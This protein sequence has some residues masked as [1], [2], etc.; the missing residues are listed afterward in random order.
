VPEEPSRSDAHRRSWVSSRIVF[1]YRVF[2]GHVMTLSKLSPMQSGIL[3][4]HRP[5]GFVLP[6]NNDHGLRPSDRFRANCDIP[7]VPL[8]HVESPL[9]CAVAWVAAKRDLK[10]VKTPV[11]DWPS[12]Q[13]VSASINWS[14]SGKLSV[15]RIS[16]SS[17]F[18]CGP[19]PPN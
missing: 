5:K 11:K 16:I 19:R 7:F 18:N 8:G 2:T 17:R 10:L 3:E 12:I 4:S 14:I 15:F 9:I 1:Q 6:Y 13:R